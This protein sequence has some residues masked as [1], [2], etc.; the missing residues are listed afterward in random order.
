[1]KGSCLCGSIGFEIDA[2]ALSAYQCHCTLCKKQSGSS[3][4]SATLVE[5]SS[6]RFI[7][8]SDLIK[9]WVKQSGFR[10][11]FCSNCGSPVPNPIRALGLIWVPLGLLPVDVKPQE[12]IHLCMSTLSSWHLVA[13]GS[14]QFQALPDLNELKKLL[15]TK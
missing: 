7:K 8:G 9:S 6:F 1:M 11:D 5:Q 12:V 10:S 14:Q 13:D 15:Q 4:N 3:S 2:D